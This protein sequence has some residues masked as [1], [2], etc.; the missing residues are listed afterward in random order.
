MTSRLV[1]ALAVGAGVVLTLV[2]LVA[3]AVYVRSALVLRRTYDVPLVP[4]AVPADTAALA[5]GARLAATRGCTGCHGERLEGRVF[6]EEPGVARLVAP[7]LT[8]AVREYS[9]AELARVIRHGVRRDGTSVFAMPSATFA[10]LSDADL[11][12][13]IAYLRSVPPA[14]GPGYELTIG[15]L[16]RFGLA[17]GKF[18]PVAAGIDHAAVGRD[19]ATPRATG[20]GGRALPQSPKVLGRYVAHTAC[21]ECHGA[22]LRGGPRTRAPSLAAVVARYSVAEF[23]TLLRTG[24]TSGGREVGLMSDMARR[25]YVHLTDDEILGLYLY[26]RSLK[27]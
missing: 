13:L 15:P 17:T 5:E 14:D 11:G 10:G 12:R 7:N 23:A 9:D 16:G 6:F 27:P 19:G 1:R 2:V 21:V 4:V 24:V 8:R 20:P 25:R 18:T 26:L 3:A 22:E